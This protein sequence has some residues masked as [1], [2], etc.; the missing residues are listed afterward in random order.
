MKPERRHELQTNTLAA[1]LGGMPEWLRQN[2]LRIVIILAIALLT[3]SAVQFRNNSRLRRQADAA[4]SLTTLRQRV[5]AISAIYYDQSQAMTQQELALRRD[6]YADSAQSTFDEVIADTDESDP[7]FRAQAYLLHGD[8]NWTLANLPM[9]PAAA[10]QPSLRVRQSSQELLDGAARDYQ[11]VIDDYPEQTLARDSALFGLAAVAEDR[12]AFDD[13]AQ[14]YQQIMND[15]SFPQ[16]LR[17][18]AKTKLADLDKMRK[19]IYFGLYPRPTTQPTTLAAQ[20]PS[21]QSPGPQPGAIPSAEESGALPPG[22]AAPA[23][24]GPTTEPDFM[25]PQPLLGPAVPIPSSP[26][27][28]PATT[29]PTGMP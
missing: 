2:A 20:S 8:L 11:R 6:G 26:S 4:Q 12:A 5:R 24:P 17:D 29:N 9:L 18:A 23:G 28:E 7:A 15:D 1:S 22:I 19:P 3:Y 16:S 13:A 27:N 21:P 25:Q 10:T 14:R